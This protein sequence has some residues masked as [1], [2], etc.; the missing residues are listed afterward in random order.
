M[1]VNKIRRLDDVLHISGLAPMSDKIGAKTD[2][3]TLACSDLL[4]TL[5]CGLG[6][7]PIEFAAL[8]EVFWL[9]TSTT[10]G[11][12]FRHLAHHLFHHGQMFEV[13]VRLE[14]GNPSEEFHQD[15]PQ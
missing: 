6:F 8:L 3:Q 7:W 14:K 9:R 1:S 12:P 5:S 11:K 10:A 13:V 2:H 15:A 4:F